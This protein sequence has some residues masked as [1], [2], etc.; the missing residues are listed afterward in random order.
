[1]ECVV[2]K[3]TIVYR[4]FRYLSVRVLMDPNNDDCYDLTFTSGSWPHWRIFHK[5]IDILL[6]KELLQ[7][8]TIRAWVL[9][10][11]PPR[12]THW[13]ITGK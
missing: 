5:N 9:Q 7:L 12:F 4:R 6:M 13:L 3:K 1:M 10:W 11:L 8:Y 2:I